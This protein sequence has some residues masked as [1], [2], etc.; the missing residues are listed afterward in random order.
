MQNPIIVL[1]SASNEKDTEAEAPLSYEHLSLNCEPVQKTADGN[2]CIMKRTII[3]LKAKN[4][5]LSAKIVTLVKS[6]RRENI[7][8]DFFLASLLDLGYTTTGR[9]IP[10]H[11]DLDESKNY[12]KEEATESWQARAMVEVVKSTIGTQVA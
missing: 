10:H 2:I 9:W 3:E 6:A 1:V 5:A 12:T 8:A 11:E 4:D 7:I